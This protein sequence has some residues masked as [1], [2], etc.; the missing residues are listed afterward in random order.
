MALCE[1]LHGGVTWGVC[2]LI[3]HGRRMWKVRE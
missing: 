2:K 1:I 3:F